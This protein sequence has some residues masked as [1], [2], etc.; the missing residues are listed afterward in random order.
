MKKDPTTEV[1]L[2]ARDLKF[3]YPPLFP[4]APETP[5]LHGV[6]LDIRRGEFVAIQGPSGSGKSTLF[7]L[8]GCLLQPTSGS[9]QFSGAETTTLSADER[10]YLRNERIGF[11]FQQFHLLSRAS[12]LENIL[13]PARYPCERPDPRIDHYKQRAKELASKLGLTEYLGRM[14]NQLS[15]GQ[16][17]RVAIARALLKDVDLVLADEPTGNLDSK[18]A[19]AI[20]EELRELNRQGKTIVLITHDLEIA[21]Q[22]GRSILV[23]DGR[24]VDGEEPKSRALPLAT[25]NEK[26]ETTGE[27]DLTP[28]G[29]SRGWRR[30]VHAWPSLKRTAQVV[31]PL[32]WENLWRNK[33]K[34]FLTM[35]GI[36]VGIAAVL[37]MVTFAR[38]VENRILESF[39]DLGAN[40]I[41]L[42]A[43]RSGG[44]KAAK[45]RGRTEFLQFT[46]EK[47]VLPLKRV[48]PDIVD[49]SPV[50]TAWNT[51]ISY[52][53]RTL[54][55]DVRIMGVQSSYLRMGRHR[56][57][58]GNVMSPLHVEQR[59]PVCVVGYEVARQLLQGEGNPIGKLVFL[60]GGESERPYVCRVIGV[61]EQQSTNRDWMKPDFM[62]LLP[63][64]YMQ[65]VVSFWA[66]LLTNVSLETREGADAEMLSE[67]IKNFFRNKYGDTA[68]IYV[69]AD[70]VMQAQIRKFLALFAVLISSVAM[71]TLVVGGIG[72]NNMM[73]VSVNER[74]K[75]IGL[76]KAIGATDRSIRVQLLLESTLLCSLAG[77]AGIVIG[78]TSYETI[79]FLASQFV[80]RLKFEWLIEPWAMGISLISILAVGILSGLTPALRAEKLQVI[81]ALRSE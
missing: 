51:T 66:G 22:C 35:I 9:I 50:L 3:A 38:F 68:D 7:Y 34:S 17:Q 40:R 48:F 13:L 56:L 65:T 79:I 39:S 2:A 63:Y 8:L 4:G 71:I 43:W 21:K 32:A 15:G 59:S 78:F 57:L 80:T 33:V 52:G 46:I 49:F 36:T 42:N 67:G 44:K 75:E 16:Q 70:A 37:A 30:L 11:V 72:I 58:L 53:G 60:T 76:R 69:G 54:S 64:T 41:S 14:P 73:L 47:D 81:E 29:L 25:L 18:N 1:V 24:I 12:V 62:V 77:V 20:M 28:A 27:I 5:I 10:A 6:S 45:K 55:N 23:R 61:L 74:L 31:L 26:P 19:A